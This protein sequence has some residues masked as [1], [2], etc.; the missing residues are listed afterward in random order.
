M[1]PTVPGAAAH[2]ATFMCVAS[3]YL[4]DESG[5]FMPPVL[6]TDQGVNPVPVIVT[7]NGS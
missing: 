3:T 6:T 7:V 1:T 4:P 2:S 5:T